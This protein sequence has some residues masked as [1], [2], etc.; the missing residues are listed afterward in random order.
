M[1]LSDM[2]YEAGSERKLRRQDRWRAEEEAQ[3]GEKKISNMY[4][5]SNTIH[6][7]LHFGNIKILL[8]EQ[9]VTPS[10]FYNLFIVG[11]VSTCY[12]M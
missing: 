5:E 6:W 9:N 11:E 4:R 8:G 1:L 3:F 2:T 7:L 12:L 10:P